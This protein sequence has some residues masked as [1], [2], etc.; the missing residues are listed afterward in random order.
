[1]DKI[2]ET[3]HEQFWNP[4]AH[5]RDLF[6]KAEAAKLPS[7]SRVL[8]AG[9]GASKYHIYFSHCRYESQ[10][11]CQY[12][13]QLVK[14]LRPIDHVCEI[15]KIPLPDQT[16]D[17]ILCTEVLEH[18]TDPMAVLKEFARLL[19][20]GG[21]LLLTTPL[22]T[23][24][25]MEPYHYYGGYTP[26]WF[27]YWLPQV[28]LRMESI[29]PQGGPG[30][31]AAVALDRFYS[32]LRTL[33]QKSSLLPRG[34]CFLLRAVLKLPAHYFL[35]WLAQRLDAKLDSYRIS[36]GFL[37]VATKLPP[38]TDPFQIKSVAV[39]NQTVVNKVAS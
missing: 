37:V 29:A 23:W 16:F 36:S 27:E 11:F 12:Q 10:D 33:E 39:W 22:G 24:L 8:D 3:R 38:G 26:Y 19:K 35:P 18:V 34:I 2:V 32:Q 15:T 4:D 20:P 28:G 30:R 21:K 25:H 6:V 7:G 17:A 14:Y 5:R 9:A 31:V 1:M 13:G